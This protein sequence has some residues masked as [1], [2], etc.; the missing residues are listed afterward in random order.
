MFH[1]YFSCFVLFFCLEKWFL[2]FVLTLLFCFLVHSVSHLLLSC[3]DVS[4]KMLFFSNKLE[5][6]SSVF[7]LSAI[8]LFFFFCSLFFSKNVWLILLFSNSI[9][10][11]F[12][13]PFSLFTFF[14]RKKSAQKP[15]FLFLFSPFFVSLCFF[16]HFSF[17]F[18]HHF[19]FDH[20]SFDPFV[21]TFLLFS[22]FSLLSFLHSSFISL[23]QCFSFSFF[24]YLMFT[25]L[26]SPSPL[27]RI[28]FLF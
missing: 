28:L 24:L 17:F 10:E 8:F 3:F 6:T 2:V 20:F 23:S 1:N 11:F 5:K 16:Q 19:F 27:L 12:V 7:S 14:S 4:E 22:P 13:N 18:Y 21:H 9:L 26:F 15:S 25:H